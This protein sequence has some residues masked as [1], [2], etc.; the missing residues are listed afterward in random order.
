VYE[1]TDLVVGRE[2][3]CAVG[4]PLLCLVIVSENVDK[5]VAVFGGY[6]HRGY[7]DTV[8]T[9]TLPQM[10]KSNDESEVPI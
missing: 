6:V 10:T 8:V 1:H 3:A 2:G 7:R 9:V 5:L 4:R